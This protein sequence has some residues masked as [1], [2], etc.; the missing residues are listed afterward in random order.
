[1]PMSALL[2][3]QFVY[4]PIGN[5]SCILQITGFV[6]GVVVRADAPLAYLA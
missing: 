5:L 6:I 1:M 3:P 2:N 4:R